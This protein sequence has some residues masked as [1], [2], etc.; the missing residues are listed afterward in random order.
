MREIHGLP[1][2]APVTI[3]MADTLNANDE[4]WG[5]RLGTG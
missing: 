5:S 2:Q 4:D 1:V 3:S